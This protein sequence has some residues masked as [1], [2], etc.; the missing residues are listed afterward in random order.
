MGPV[1]IPAALQEY[2]HTLAAGWKTTNI[3]MPQKNHRLLTTPQPRSAQLG[4]VLLVERRTTGV[5]IIRRTFPCVPYCSLA[6]LCLAAIAAS[7]VAPVHA[8]TTGGISITHGGGNVNAAK[9]ALSEADQG[10]TTLGGTAA[11]R[12][13]AFTNGGNNRNIASGALSF[14][15]QNV[16]T[17]GGTA[18][19]RGR[20]ITNGGS[21]LNLARGFGST[22][23]QSIATLGGTAFG[24]GH[25]GDQ[26]RLQHQPRGRGVLLG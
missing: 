16:T 20:V 18:I 19:G 3:G 10:V 12:G 6:S 14:A 26:R 9:G 13:V 8:Q 21:N 11:G 17:L 7:T 4:R 25:L 2:L 5:R 22:A 1:G 24:R 23:T 15:G